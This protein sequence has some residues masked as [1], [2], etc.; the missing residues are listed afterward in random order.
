MA[1]M[2]IGLVVLIGVA[3]GPG[4]L[5]IL[6]RGSKDTTVPADGGASGPGCKD[7]L[8]PPP[9]AASTDNQGGAGSDLTFAADDIRL[10]ANT[11]ITNATLPVPIGIDLD[12]RCTC[13]PDKPSCNP[14]ADA[15][16]VCDTDGG[17]D[18]NAATLLGGL[19][20]FVPALNP[21]IVRKRITD[22][23]YSII[24]D[25]FEWNG[26]A[27]DPSVYVSVRM[28]PGIANG[29]DENGQPLPPKLDGTDT[30]AID[31]GTIVDAPLMLQNGQPCGKGT[32]QCVA[33][34]LDKNAYVT[35]NKVVAKFDRLNISITPSGA[36][37][38]ALPYLGVTLVATISNDPNTGGYKLAG[39]MSGRWT[40]NEIL[41]AAGALGSEQDAGISALTSVCGA[42]YGLFKQNLC[43]ATDLAANPADDNKGKT[44]GALSETMRFD[45]IQANAGVVR[46]PTTNL[47]ACGGHEGDT[48]ETSH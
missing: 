15:S 38:L 13:Y 45:A 9:P 34:A 42:G 10:D 12:Q 24:F 17:A 6:T 20:N 26:K 33:T 7:I 21:A 28:S 1:A 11:A 8:P 25:V 22:G 41:A 3:C 44:C 18:N 14:F 37:R 30:W 36:G 46:Q 27:D 31:P 5:S 32:G 23:I 47:V 16:I 48:C 35:G 2:G 29:V 19:I 39:E 4:D 40:A 43:S